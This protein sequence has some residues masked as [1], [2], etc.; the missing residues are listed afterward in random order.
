VNALSYLRINQ[1][2]AGWW[3]KC[4]EGLMME[5]NQAWIAVYK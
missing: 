1:E 3:G 5:G 4:K 2:R